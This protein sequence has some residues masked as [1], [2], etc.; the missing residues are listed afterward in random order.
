[1]LDESRYERCVYVC[2]ENDVI[3]R[4][5]VVMEMTDDVK[6]EVIMECVTDEKDSYRRQIIYRSYL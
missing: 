4:Q 2:P 6:A 1:M 3:D 5:S